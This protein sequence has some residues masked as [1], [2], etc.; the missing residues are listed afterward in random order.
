MENPMLKSLAAAAALSFAVMAPG[1]SAQA[2]D[3]SGAALVD[4]LLDMVSSEADLTMQSKVSGRLAQGAS[5][6]ATIQVPSG[7]V[8][9]IGVCDENCSD[10]DMIV[11][12]PSGREM[13]RDF[14]DDDVPMVVF[15][16]ATAG[17][18]TVEVQ[19][20]AC[21]GTCNWGVGVFN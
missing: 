2:Q 15:E 17:R 13:G 16:A 10:V 12:D 8:A 4:L 6:T 11:R 3:P 7:P 9:F 20:P 18:Y 14:E 19:M 21:N 5:N 1:T